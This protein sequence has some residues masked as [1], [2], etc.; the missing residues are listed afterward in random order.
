MS[1]IEPVFRPGGFHHV[2]YHG[3]T[4]SK[5]P[6]IGGYAMG[7]KMLFFRGP[8]LIYDVSWE[9]EVIE[10]DYAD[11]PGHVFKIGATEED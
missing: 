10:G 2:L 6:R 4:F 11:T 3:T 8:V 7:A 9:H 5:C 1:G